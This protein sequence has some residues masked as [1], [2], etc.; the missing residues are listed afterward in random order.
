AALVIFASKQYV[1]VGIVGI[2]VIDLHPI[3]AGAEISLHLPHQV[4]CVCLEVFEL[5]YILSRHDEAE[6]MPIAGAPIRKG[7]GISAIGAS[8][9]ELSSP[10]ILVHTGTL[11]VVLR[12]VER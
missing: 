7:L 1:R 5:G 3:E 2:P 4:A 9:I 12:I 11:D 10:T 6:L 8:R